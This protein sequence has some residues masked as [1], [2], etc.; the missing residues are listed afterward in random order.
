MLS[1]KLNSMIL[2]KLLILCICI[3]NDQHEA[4]S[5]MFCINPRSE[6]G[7]LSSLGCKKLSRHYTECADTTK[8]CPV[9]A[10]DL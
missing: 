10:V 1:Q 3:Y 9:P 6:L 5:K 2:F 4:A 7:V 8:I